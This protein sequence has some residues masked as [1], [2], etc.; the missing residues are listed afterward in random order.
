[1]IS[2]EHTGEIEQ[3]K[4]LPNKS[5]VLLAAISVV[6]GWRRWWCKQRQGIWEGI[7]GF[8][9]LTILTSNVLI[10]SPKRVFTAMVK[11]GHTSNNYLQI[12]IRE[13]PIN[14]PACWRVGLHGPWNIHGNIASLHHEAMQSKVSQTTVQTNSTS[15]PF[16]PTHHKWGEG[17]GCL[18]KSKP[19]RE[20]AAVQKC[21]SRGWSRMPPHSLEISGSPC[22]LQLCI[23][24]PTWKNGLGGWHVAKEYLS[25][26]H[27]ET[28]GLRKPFWVLHPNMSL[29]HGKCPW[30][31]GFLHTWFGPKIQGSD[32]SHKSKCYNEFIF[33]VP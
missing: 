8:I 1:M 5:G 10:E 9:F 2:P 23:K 12:F 7:Q 25:I 11:A 31:R 4:R 33:T 20:E 32:S 18:W 17:D 26:A 13:I 28:H 6:R 29:F 21:P 3:M 19:G 24:K 15:M 14:R 27:H 30:P 22:V 16:S